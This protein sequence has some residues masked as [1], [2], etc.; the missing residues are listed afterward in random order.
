MKRIVSVTAESLG[1]TQ[2]ELIL[3][4]PLHKSIIWQSL[5]DALCSFGKK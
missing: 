5:I 3:E 2:V 1:K 4:R